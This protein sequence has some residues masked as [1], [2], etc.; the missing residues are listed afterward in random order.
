MVEKQSIWAGA[1]MQKPPKK[2]KRDRTTDRLN[3]RQSGLKSRVYLTK[4]E[5]QIEK[6]KK[7]PTGKANSNPM[8]ISFF[9][10]P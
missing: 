9:N 3:D 8:L 6:A 5:W 2:A 4:N 1:E 7:L 10:S